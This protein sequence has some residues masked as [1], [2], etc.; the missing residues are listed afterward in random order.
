[1]EDRVIDILK[2]SESQ[3]AILS[4]TDG[5]AVAEDAV[6]Y[7]GVFPITQGTYAVK[8][9]AASAGSVRLKIELE[10]GFS[11]PATA[12]AA[13][14]DWAVP[15]GAS[16]FNNT[17]QDANVHIKAYA[18]AAAP[19]ARFKITGNESNAATTKITEL[20]VNVIR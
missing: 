1:M 19:Y 4:A 15:D 9:K 3:G 12:G 6:K 7:S 5:I 11:L 2:V 10:Q 17:L 13:S 20:K 16:E 18:P 8:Y 14:T